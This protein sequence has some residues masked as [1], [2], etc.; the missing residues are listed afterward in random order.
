MLNA[1]VIKTRLDRK[2]V[3]I[4][5]LVCVTAIGVRVMAREP[6]WPYSP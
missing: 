5:A 4:S 6:S 2:A 3:T 1:I